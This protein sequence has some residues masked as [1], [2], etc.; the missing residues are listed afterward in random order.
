MVKETLLDRGARKLKYRSLLL[1]KQM[2]QSLANLRNGQLSKQVV[3]VAGVQRSGTNMMMDVLE[4]SFE[5]EVY[6]E[7]D[8][9]AFDQYQMRPREVIHG[10]VKAAKAP[11]VIFKA[12]CELQELR[13]LLDEFMPAKAVWIVRRFED[14]VNSHIALWNRM[15]KDL[16]EI[17]KDR[18]GAAGWRGRGMSDATHDLVRRFYHPDISNESACALFWCFRNGLFFE[19]GFDRDQRVLLVCYE[20]LVTS[21]TEQFSRLFNFLGIEYTTYVSSKV[22]ASSVRKSSSPVIEPPIR[23]LC[24][25]LTAKFEALLAS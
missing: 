9:R 4:R 20:S 24:E 6:H 10:L 18:N 15:P 13:Q 2:E 19:H 8:P 25:A 17:V 11:Q 1:R 12:L 21:P 14:V 16:A 23:E 5:T 3:F 22:F 7:R